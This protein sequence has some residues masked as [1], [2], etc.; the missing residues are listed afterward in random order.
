MDILTNT[1]SGVAGE[2]NVIGK[3]M[4]FGIKI[5]KPFWN[6]DEV[7]FEIKFGRGD[8]SINISVQVKTVQFNK[9]SDKIFIQGLKKKYVERNELLCL[10]VYNPQFDWFWFI[11]GNKEIIKTYDNQQDWN[12]K[13][14]YYKDLNND[15]DVRIGVSKDGI[16]LLTSYKIEIN[17]K[18]KLTELIKKN[19]S[20]KKVTIIPE[21]KN[22]LIDL[23]GKIQLSLNLEEKKNVLSKPTEF[24]IEGS[25][26]NVITVAH[27][28]F[29]E[30]LD[31]NQIEKDLSILFRELFINSIAHRSYEDNNPNRVLLSKNKIVI[32]NPGG[33]VKE[34]TIN[35]LLSKTIVASRNP[36]LSYDLVKAGLMESFGSGLY[37]AKRIAATLS[38]WEINFYI[39][40]NEFVAEITKNNVA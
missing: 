35:D 25:I 17:D 11:S 30:F 18:E 13:H 29:Q 21:E 2:Q 5:S 37:S 24:N 7:D 8:N 31:K 23:K 28:I 40:N 27:E 39:D 32:S 20:R 19:A 26:P 12:K 6:D 9:K 33:L 10:A 22:D 15:D 4:R 3:L 38:N 16:S 14:K 34:L 1:E 36:K